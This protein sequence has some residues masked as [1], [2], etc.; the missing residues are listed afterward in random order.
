M[1]NMAQPF[2]SLFLDKPKYLQEIYSIKFTNKS[3]NVISEILNIRESKV[4]PNGIGYTMI[5][6]IKFKKEIEK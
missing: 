4:D 5:I 1:F 2:P 6:I 3:S